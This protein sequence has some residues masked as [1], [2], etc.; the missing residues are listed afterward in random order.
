MEELDDILLCYYRD[1]KDWVEA[2]APDGPIFTREKTLLRA[3]PDWCTARGV[4]F[5]TVR[6]HHRIRLT[7][8]GMD[9]YEDFGTFLTF[10]DAD[11]APGRWMCAKTYLWVEHVL[12]IGAFPVCQETQ[13][14]LGRFYQD[15]R[16][17]LDNGMPDSRIFKKDRPLCPSLSTWSVINH[18]VGNTF[19]SV[20]TAEFELAG[21]DSVRPFNNGPYSLDRECTLNA[22]YDNP[23]RI[24]W[25]EQRSHYNP[26]GWRRIIYRLRKLFTK[27]P[28]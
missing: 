8:G 9:Y 10:R 23:I 1:W 13:R 12:T 26:K 15:C 17:W 25:I 5:D 7:M 28:K 18:G 21:L 2:D 3:L 24:A 16:E 19:N 22:I 4:D 6:N 20:M 14:E 11:N 27:E